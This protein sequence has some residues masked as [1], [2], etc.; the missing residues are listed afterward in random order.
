MTA[1]FCLG[2]C[3]YVLKKRTLAQSLCVHRVVS[4]QN[5]LSVPL[6]K[7]VRLNPLARSLRAQ[8]LAADARLAAALASGNP[9]L[10]A[11]ARA[12]QKAVL[13][14]QMALQKKQL[15]LLSEARELRVDSRLRLMREVRPLKSSPLSSHSPFPLALAVRP[16]PPG[17]LTPDYETVPAFELAQSEVYDFTVDLTPP[18]ADNFSPLD[19]RQLTHCSATLSEVQEEKWRPKILAASAP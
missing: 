8:K 13:L 17:N 2:T 14:A 1:V 3:L 11:A 18:F 6:E 7:L 4:L 12:L 15:G 5:D 10:I 19:F 9:G 16:L